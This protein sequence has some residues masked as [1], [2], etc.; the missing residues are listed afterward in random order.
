MP[1]RDWVVSFYGC[2]KA[3]ELATGEVVHRWT[4]LY[5]G[6]QVG[7][8]DIGEPP[9]PPL[10]LDPERGRFALSSEKGV[11]VVTLFS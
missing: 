11:T 8:I 10:A 6:K 3:I 5:S 9:P 7:A 4:Q 1:W 2:P